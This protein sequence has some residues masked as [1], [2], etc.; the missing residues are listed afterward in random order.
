MKGAVIPPPPQQ[1]PPARPGSPLFLPAA[2]LFWP[3]LGNRQV[4]PAVLPPSA[5]PTLKEGVPTQRRDNGHK[6]SNRRGAGRGENGP[7]AARRPLQ[8]GEIKAGQTAAEHKPSRPL[9]VQLARTASRPFSPPRG[10]KGAIAL[11]QSNRTPKH[12]K[13]RGRA[14]TPPLFRPPPSENPLP[15]PWR[16]NP[17][18]SASHFSHLQSDAAALGAWGHPAPCRPAP[19]PSAFAIFRRWN[20]LSPSPLGGLSGRPFSPYAK[21]RGG[22]GRAPLPRPSGRATRAKKEPRLHGQGPLKRQVFPP[23]TAPAPRAGG[24]DPSR[25][26]GRSA[27]AKRRWPWRSGDSRKIPGRPRG[28][29]GEGPAGSGAGAP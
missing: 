7:R 14:K 9:G 28:G 29:W 10:K 11:P 24:R 23:A 8:G 19:L 1:A 26:P 12:K 17:F 27:A 6:P 2:A 3:R 22:E 25:C 21:S 16:S 4:K 18:P 15:P 13:A 5:T 20:S